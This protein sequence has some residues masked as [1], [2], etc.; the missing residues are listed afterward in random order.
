VF[1][2]PVVDDSADHKSPMTALPNSSLHVSAADPRLRWVGRTQIRASEAHESGEQSSERRSSAV[3]FAWS[4]SGLVARFYG[5]GLGCV[6]ADPSNYFTV[7][8][9]G[10]PLRAPFF[11][12]QTREHVLVEG[13]E[14]GE[15]TVQLL[16]RSEAAFG[17]SE[18]ESVFVLGGHLQ[19]GTPAA[20]TLEVLGDS[21]SCGYGNETSH[22]SAVFSASTENHYASYVAILARSLDAEVSTVAWS[23]RG[24]VRNYG[25]AP[26]PL[27][28][29]LYLRTLPDASSG[30]WPFADTVDLVIVNLGTNDF[31]T[32]GP[33]L[34]VFVA[35]YAALLQSVRER[36]PTTPILSTLGPMLA[37]LT[38]N[39][40]RAAIER[41]V[42]LRREQGDANV[43]Y[44]AIQTP[45][46]AP[47][48]NEHP[49]VATHA[50]VA[51]ELLPVVRAL[52]G[53][54]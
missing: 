27:M 12:G 49:S 26:E 48:S 24:V 34:D 21:I 22:P 29:E 3:R 50:A 32:P 45:N 8:V 25:D 38:R 7:V 39:R 41:A 51:Q 52:L 20:T 46:R 19:S 6:L 43:H 35:G 16:R 14:L 44:Y 47:G 4:G 17:V 2:W 42:T 37:P 10:A 54:E 13:L 11:A 33:S 9:D 28:P 23:G 36:R 53:R 15:H 1:L 40:A 18:V 30:V 5:T 31:T